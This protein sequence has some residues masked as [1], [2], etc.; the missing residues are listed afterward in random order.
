MPTPSENDIA[1]HTARFIAMLDDA[2]RHY[3]S[4]EGLPPRLQDAV[5]AT[6]RHRFVHRF[7]LGDGPL[8][9]LDAEPDQ[10]LPAIYSDQVMRHVD[11]AGELLPSSNSQ[12]SYVLWRPCCTD[13]GCGRS[14]PYPVCGQAMRTEIGRPSSSMRLRTWTATSTSVA[15]RSSVRERSPSPMTCLNLPMAASARARLV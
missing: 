6:P 2:F 9:D 3:G 11:A 14:C 15:R 8:Q 4:P 12:P 13:Q 5:A 1:T 10:T 7:R